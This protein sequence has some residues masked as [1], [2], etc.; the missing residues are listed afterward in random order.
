[1]IRILMGL[2]VLA[3]MCAFAGL[4]LLGATQASAQDFPVRAVKVIIGFTPGGG[5]D[6]FGRMIA[7]KMSALLGQSFTVENRPGANGNLAANTV[8]KSGPDGYTLLFVASTHVSNG[9]LYANLPYDP[10]TD[11]VPVAL[12]VSMPLLLVATP[13]FPPNDVQQLIAYARQNP[14]KV[15]FAS[16]GMGAPAHLA[17]EMFKSAAGLDIQMIHYKGAGPAQADVMGGHVNLQIATFAQA[18]PL[19]SA[20][21]LKILAQTGITRSS[22]A[23]QIPTIDESGLPGYHADTWFGMVAPAGVPVPVLD[24]L[25]KVMNEVLTDPV[26]VARI[27]E[28]G[29]EPM[30][31]SREH[32]ARLMQQEQVKWRKVIKEVGIG[33][34][35]E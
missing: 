25:N 26:V 11:L 29:A 31:G 32:A 9:D 10:M 3:R 8:A 30:G 22:L 16:P 28:L 4:T 14:G 17:M 35:P 34:K 15:T 1:M 19:A 6:I 7:E 24:R 5:A 23:K 12:G 18:M 2:R 21:K 20:G 13:S 27:H 33:L